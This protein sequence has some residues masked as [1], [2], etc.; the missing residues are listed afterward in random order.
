MKNTQSDTADLGRFR[1][2]TPWGKVNMKL[3]H[4]LEEIEMFKGPSMD[5]DDVEW[6]WVDDRINALERDGRKLTREELEMANGLWKTYGEK[7]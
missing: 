2:D 1:G 3:K 5:I 6:R 4:L 7:V